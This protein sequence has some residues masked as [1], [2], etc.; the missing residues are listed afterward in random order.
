M[1]LLTQ[2]IIASLVMYIAW[3]D[4]NFT[5]VWTYRPIVLGPLMGL[6]MGNLS[7]GLEVGATVELMYLATV[8][9]GTATPP[10][11]TLAA[12]IG[13]A[14]A[15]V[16]GDTTVAIAAAIPIGV[17]GGSL[18][19]L[20]QTVL[21]VFTL[22]MYEKEMAKGNR[23]G[24]I[25]WAVFV[26]TFVINFVLFVVPTFIAVYFGADV[27][28]QILE[29][30]PENVLAAINC[31]GKMIGAVGLALLLKMIGFNRAWPFFFLGFIFSAYL[32]VG[33]LGI[34]ILGVVTVAIIYMYKEKG[35][36]K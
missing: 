14:L 33:N 23:K 20:R 4:N 29:S 7:I 36:A 31:G 28:T 16:T 6:C 17:L 1:P 24:M 3:I 2:A 34:T 15:V 10:N 22:K 19:T 27:C 18:V 12:G 30:I 25:F 5:H 9:V 21:D 35:V 13:T 8:W 32:G 26:P 11:E